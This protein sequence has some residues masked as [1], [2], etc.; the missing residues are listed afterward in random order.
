MRDIIFIYLDGSTVRQ[1]TLTGAAADRF[2]VGLG[3]RM[4]GKIVGEAR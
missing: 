1:A 2:E 4:L 3:N